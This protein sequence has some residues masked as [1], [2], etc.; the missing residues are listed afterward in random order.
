MP[1]GAPTCWLS[2]WVGADPGTGGEGGLVKSDKL[3]LQFESRSPHSLAVF[4]D[5]LPA[6]SEPV[7]SIQWE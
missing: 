3:G 2:Q 7:S 5:K 1:Q 4:L 6:L